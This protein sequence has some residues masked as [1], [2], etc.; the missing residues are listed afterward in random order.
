RIRAAGGDRYWISIRTR[1]DPRDSKQSRGI[2]VDITEQKFAEGEAALRREEIAQLKRVR[3][4]EGRLITINAMS[5]SIAHEISQPIGAMMAS[6]DAALLWL[7]KAPPE[8]GN[9][10]DSV[11]RITIDGRRA[12][13]VVASVRNLFRRDVGGKEPIDVDDLVREIL[14]IEQDELQRQG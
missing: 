12:T 9:V 2:F 14:A 10:R 8:L 6:A 1:L 11:E 7:A 3:E 5:A 13:E 4:R